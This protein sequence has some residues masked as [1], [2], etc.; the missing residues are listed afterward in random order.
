MGYELSI[1]RA[2]EANKISIKEWTNYIN[3]DPEFEAI[4]EFSADIKGGEVL[5]VSTPNAGLWKSKNGEVPFT[6]SEKYGMITVKNP[7]TWIIE[8][9]ISIAKKLNAVVLGEEGEEYDEEYL[10]DA[11]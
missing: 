11:F 1:Q 8:K 7:D 10:K 6:F 5:T 3:S 9:M 4:E 2:N